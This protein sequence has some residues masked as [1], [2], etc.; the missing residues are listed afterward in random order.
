MAIDYV[1]EALVG[2]EALPFE[3]GSPVV[4]ETP[5]P[6][7]PTVVPELAEGL[8]ED[9]GRVEALVG[10]QQNLERALALQGEVFVARQQIVL[11]ALE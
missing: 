9:V 11:L 10:C 6:A 5:R 2:S 8:L 1:G 4:E 3:A 7:F